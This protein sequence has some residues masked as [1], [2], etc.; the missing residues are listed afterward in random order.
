[1]TYNF[2][3]A[4]DLTG[5]LEN[6]SSSL[7]TYAYDDLGRRTSLTRG[8][9]V[10]TSYTFDAL[11]RLSTLVQNASGSSY[12]TTFTLGY[13][14]GSQITSRTRTNGAFDWTLPASFS[15]SYTANGLNQYTNAD[16]VT[17]TYDT[18][19]NLTNDG[20]KT[21][22]YDYDNRMISASGGVSLNYDPAGRLHQVA[23]AST[24]QF[25]YDG[26]DMIAEY[27]G[28]TVLRRY[29]HGPGVDEPLLWYEGSGTSDKRYL[30]ADERGSVIG[31]TNSSGA[32][33]QVNRYDAYGV[34]DSGN[35]GQFQYT[36]Q[37]WID[38]LDLYHYKA[39]V[40]DPEL[41]RFLQTDPIGTAGGINLYA[42]VGND[43]VNRTDP[44]GLCEFY[45]TLVGYQTLR[46]TSIEGEMVVYGEDKRPIY[47]FVMGGGDCNPSYTD[48][49]DYLE[50]QDWGPA[51]L[52]GHDYFEANWVCQ[53][54]ATANERKDLLSRF[55]LPNDYTRGK[56]HSDGFHWVTHK[57]VPIGLVRMRFGDDGLRVT[58]TTTPIH[59][60]RGRIDRTIQ[61]FEVG[62]AA[63]THGVGPFAGPVDDAANQ[64]LGP[65]IFR[66]LDEAGAQ[67]ASTN[68]GGC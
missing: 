46:T 58:N 49:Q 35:V 63:I 57:Y 51:P 64:L 8:N 39:R 65:G 40:Y 22:G 36:G 66:G 20:S 3:T 44:S 56:V 45:R 7:A 13:N 18:R 19:G 34:P 31:V 54:A 32:V 10:V 67:Y 23:G 17:P 60:F 2:N 41:G 5:I 61:N 16:G 21:Y 62:A 6:G 28:S 43:P 9:G 33:T 24:T 42:Y 38:D 25:L 14:A 1:V 48:V 47:R 4:S 53:R 37:R 30:M 15:D 11:S 55:S 50:S 27:N 29:V 68:F 26:A 12:D 59:P 52:L